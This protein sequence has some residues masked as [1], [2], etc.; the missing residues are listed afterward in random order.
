MFLKADRDT[1]GNRECVSAVDLRHI[2]DL[3][4][5]YKKTHYNICEI[6]RDNIRDEHGRI[7]IEIEFADEH[8]HW[9]RQKLL[10]MNGELIDGVSFHKRCRE[11]YPEPHT[12]ASE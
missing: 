4:D 5:G 12:V 7:D 8:G 6:R 9:V 10:I 3:I 11:W 2:L 1:Y